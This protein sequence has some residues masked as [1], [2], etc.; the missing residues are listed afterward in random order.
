V[1]DPIAILAHRQM[2]RRGMSI[3]DLAEAAEVHR[4]V[5]GRWLAGTRSIR[6]ADAVRVMHV[7]GIVAVVKEDAHGTPP[8]RPL[9]HRPANPFPRRPHQ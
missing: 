8:A 4:S 9:Q 1:P 5:L 3:C 6:L 7:L 2:Q